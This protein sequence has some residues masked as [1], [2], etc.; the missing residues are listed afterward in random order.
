MHRAERPARTAAALTDTDGH[1]YSLFADFDHAAI[2]GFYWALYRNDRSS[3][4][5]PKP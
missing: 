5:V 2:S 1:R 4:T 3:T